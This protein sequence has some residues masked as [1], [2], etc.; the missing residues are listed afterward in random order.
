MSEKQA[1]DGIR[2]RDLLLTLRRSRASE[3][4]RNARWQT[5]RVS[6]PLS[7]LYFIFSSGYEAIA[8]TR[9]SY[10]GKRKYETPSNELGIK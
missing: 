5:L 9:L 1:L 6:L 10:Q 3:R 4:E 7:S 8:L 2:A